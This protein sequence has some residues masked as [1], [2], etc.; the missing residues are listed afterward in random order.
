MRAL[1]LTLVLWAG[2]AGARTLEAGSG[3]AYP[4]PSAAARA[5]QDGDT[6][7]IAPGEY[8]DCIVSDRRITIQGPA[9]LTDKTCEGKALLVLRGNGVTVR[10]LTLAR[11]RVPDSNG[12][13]IRLEGRDALIE[14]VQF[15]NNEVGVLGGAGVVTLRGCTITAGQAGMT[16][17]LVGDAD[18]LAVQD[19]RVSVQ[20]GLAVSSGAGLT[21]ITGGAIE[22]SDQGMLL[23]GP[24]TI[25]GV[26]LTLHGAA[27]S[28]ARAT[29]GHVT[30]RHTHLVNTTGHGV[31]LLQDWGPGAV[32]VDGNTVGP[33]DREVTTAGAWRYRAG[34]AARG[35]KAGVRDLARAAKHAVLGP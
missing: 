30:I 19:T 35:A 9:T 6:I 2:S 23:T 16:A 29:G 4:T 24:A 32:T 17:I 20:H 18:M 22:T 7:Q 10:D 1:A 31:A 15:E 11:A 25:E 28:F 27:T 3:L 21:T 33:G 26:A 12:A 5:A 8:Y 13:G 14:R 34:I